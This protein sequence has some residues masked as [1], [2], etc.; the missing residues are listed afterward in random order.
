[1]SVSRERIR[2]IEKEGL[3]Q[4]KRHASSETLDRNH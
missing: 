2:Q 4:L 1:L 3:N